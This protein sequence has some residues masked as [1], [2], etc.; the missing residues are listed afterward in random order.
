MK[1]MLSRIPFHTGTENAAKPVK[2]SANPRE[3]DSIFLRAK[4]FRVLLPP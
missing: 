3:S 1:T 2:T 4:R